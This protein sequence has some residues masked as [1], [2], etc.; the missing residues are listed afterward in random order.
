M[1][2]FWRNITARILFQRDDW[3]HAASLAA[4]RVLIGWGVRIITMRVAC[5]REAE[6]KE[7]EELARADE[8]MK[9]RRKGSASPFPSHPILIHGGLCALYYTTFHAGLLS[10]TV[11]AQLLP[12]SSHS[13]PRTHRPSRH[14]RLN[15]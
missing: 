6:R 10:F 8:A 11:P 14:T 13:L 12:P 7:R 1:S 2:A 15:E 3:L 9:L 4:P 5:R